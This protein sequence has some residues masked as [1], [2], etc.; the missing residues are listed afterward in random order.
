MNTFFYLSGTIPD[1]YNY[2]YSSG[3]RRITTTCKKYLDNYIFKQGLLY[4]FGFL[5]IDHHDS[6]GGLSQQ[7]TINR[8]KS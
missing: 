2:F 3:S 5:H 7:I 6:H 4:Q 8:D 1:D